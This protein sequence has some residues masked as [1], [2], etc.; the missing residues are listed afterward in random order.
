MKSLFVNKNEF[1]LALQ[2]QQLVVPC[3]NCVQPNIFSSFFIFLKSGEF[4]LKDHNLP[5]VFSKTNLQNKKNALPKKSLIHPLCHINL[6][7]F[8]SY[9][10]LNNQPLVNNFLHSYCKY[11]CV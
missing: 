8:I 4:S 3:G 1:K 7:S 5:N 11:Y 2:Y 6:T 9:L 10:I